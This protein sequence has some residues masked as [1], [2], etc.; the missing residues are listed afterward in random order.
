MEKDNHTILGYLSPLA[1]IGLWPS[2]F[3]AIVVFGAAK[4][5]YLT[6]IRDIPGPFLASFSRLWQVYQLWR[7][8]TEE[9][10]IKLHKRHGHFVH[11]HDN[12]VSVS[13]PDAVKQLLHTNIVKGPWYSIFSLP[14]YHYVNQMSELNPRRHIEKNKNVTSSVIANTRALAL[15]IAV[16]G[17]YVWLHNLT[18]GNPILSRIGIQ[19]SSTPVS[20]LLIRANRTLSPAPT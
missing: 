10:V 4:R 18:L 2:I 16:M 12:E 6:P 14:D 13:H 19:P 5:K 3:V 20:R 15:Y 17:H 8:H 11:I 1:I 9:E 7:G